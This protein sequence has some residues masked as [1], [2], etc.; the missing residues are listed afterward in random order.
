MT[1]TVVRAGDLA[2][3]M[4]RT[5]RSAKRAAGLGVLCLVGL[6]ASLVWQGGFTGLIVCGVVVSAAALWARIENAQERQRLRRLIRS[7]N[8]TLAIKGAPPITGAIDAGLLL[9]RGFKA[10]TIDRSQGALWFFRSAKEAYRLDLAVIRGI[11]PGTRRTWYG[12]VI[13]TLSLS[14]QF[15]SSLDFDVREGD[16]DGFLREARACA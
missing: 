8:S 10:V 14:D 15:G 2:D 1:M 13:N 7:G 6:A 11:E 12:K 3:Q 5:L 9:M 4:Q 16:I